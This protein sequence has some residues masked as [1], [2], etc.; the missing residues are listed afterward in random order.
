MENGGGGGVESSF[1]PILYATQSRQPWVMLYLK[2]LL[3][4]STTAKQIWVI[5]FL[6]K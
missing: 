6:L 2:Q 5:I 3:S 4:K 1:K